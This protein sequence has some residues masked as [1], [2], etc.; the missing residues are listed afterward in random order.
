MEAWEFG[1]D[2]IF[3]LWKVEIVP[4]QNFKILEG[5]VLE[6]FVKDGKDFFKR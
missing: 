6:A 3:G 1:G 5:L 2:E 4:H